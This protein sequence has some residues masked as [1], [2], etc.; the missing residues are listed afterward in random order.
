MGYRISSAVLMGVC[1]VIVVN[2][3]EAAPKGPELFSQ[4]SSLLR[5]GKVQT[6]EMFDGDL[7]VSV[8]WLWYNRAQ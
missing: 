6:E 4:W 2:F 5:G 1:Q 7:A 8:L 3:G